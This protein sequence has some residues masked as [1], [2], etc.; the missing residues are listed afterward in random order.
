[1]Q[2]FF[3]S[4]AF[5]VC[6]FQNV[7]VSK[8]S[9]GIITFINGPYKPLLHNFICNMEKLQIKSLLHVF[10][11]DSQLESFVQSKN[12]SYTI[13]DKITTVNNSVNYGDDFYWYISRQKILSFLEAV[14]IYKKYIFTDVDVLW[15]KNPITDLEKFCDIDICF[16]SNT[17]NGYKFVNSGFFFVNSSKQTLNFFKNSL[18]VSNKIKYKKL[19]DQD[20]INDVLQNKQN[21]INW[22]F[23]KLEYYPNGGV[24][25]IWDNQR[26]FLN[27][28]NIFVIHNNWIISLKNKTKRFQ[29]VGGWYADGDNDCQF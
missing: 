1:M 25:N 4:V 29:K 12:I 13:L 28:S 21:L 23:L 24:P 15:L 18:R 5:F 20:V 8:N 9:I 26:N 17:P 27:T 7:L 6:F 3:F 16:Q 2:L 10:L 19:G 22:K 14:K 11:A